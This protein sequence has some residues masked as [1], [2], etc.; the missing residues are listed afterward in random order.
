[1][2]DKDSGL[3]RGIVPLL[4]DPLLL[5]P[6]RVLWNNESRSSVEG[7][8]PSMILRNLISE[9]ALFEMLLE[10]RRGVLTLSVKEPCGAA[11]I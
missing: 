6:D 8:L 2:T 4:S 10:A 1:M 9:P 5:V 3:S 11:Q 7:A